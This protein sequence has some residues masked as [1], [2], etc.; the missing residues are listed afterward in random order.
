VSRD[1]GTRFYRLPLPIKQKRSSTKRQSEHI[2]MKQILLIALISLAVLYIIILI[3]FYCFQEKLL[4]IPQK[5]GKDYTFE[6]DQT[7]EEINTITTDGALLNGLLFKAE[8]TR[9]L[10]FYLHG[11]AGCIQG[12]GKVAQ[13]Y[14][15]LGFDIF[16]LDYRGYGKSEGTITSEEQLFSDNQLVYTELMKSYNEAETI[17][18]AYSIG[19]GLAA[20]LA[21]KNNPRLLILQA[22]YYSITDL[23]QRT[24][25]FL[26]LP[27]FLMKYKFATNEY[28]KQCKMPV[29]IFHGDKDQLIAFKS[30]LKLK[31]EFKEQDTLITLKGQDHNGMSDTDDYKTELKKVLLK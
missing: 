22:P 14:T 20:E 25:P 8:T 5:L 12:W 21:A 1:T 24:F 17:I 30:S 15:D 18:M 19:T 13:T 23:A 10:I 26:L 2:D 6:F 29:V 11:N 9:G 7:F 4:F 3:L 16:I 27:K 31:E 28:L